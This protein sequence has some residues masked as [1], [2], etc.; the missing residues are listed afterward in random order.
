M[1]NAGLGQGKDAP[2]GRADI[3]IQAAEGESEPLQDTPRFVLT[4]ASGD[5]VR[6]TVLGRQAET[7]GQADGPSKDP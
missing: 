6:R 5:E 1:N 3:D 7:R 2:E 4:W